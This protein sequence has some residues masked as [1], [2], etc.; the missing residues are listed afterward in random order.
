MGTGCRVRPPQ[1]GSGDADLAA[2][3]VTRRRWAEPWR[4]AAVLTLQSTLVAPALVPGSAEEDDWPE[5]DFGVLR[6]DRWSAPH[7]PLALFGPA[8]ADWI[9]TAAAAAACPPDYVAAP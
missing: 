6:P 5:P 3:C 4:G 7:L 9:T 8:W 1:P 2:N